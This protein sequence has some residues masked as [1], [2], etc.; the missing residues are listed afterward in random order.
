MRKNISASIAVGTLFAAFLAPDAASEDPQLASLNPAAIFTHLDLDRAD[1]GAVR[2]LVLQGDAPNALR[3]LRDHY[4]A[5]YPLPDGEPKIEQA[6]LETADRTA[7]HIFQWGP[8]EPAEY[9]KDVDWAWDP[10]GD[11]EWVAAM[12]RFYWADALVQAYQATRDERY[13]EAFVEL[14]S[15]WIAKHPLQERDK[16]HPVYTNW[17][18]YPW[19]DIQTGI[20]AT[21]LCRAFPVMVHAE[22]FTPEFLGVFLASLYDHQAKTEFYPM[23]KVHN[24]AIFEQRGFVN[25]AYTFPEFRDS[26]RWLELALGRARESLLDQ[27][28]GD[29]V[30]REWSAGYHQGVLRDAVEMMGRMEERGISV[31]EDYRARV[32][33][34]WE[35][36]F[37]MSTPD[38]GY[39]M[40]GD[41]SRPY[42]SPAQRGKM[43]LYGSMLLAAEVLSDPRFAALALNQTDELPALKSY[44]FPE[45][46]MYFLRDAWGPKQIYFALHCSPPGISGHDQPDNGTFEVCAFGRWLMTDSGYYTYGHDPEARAWHR[47]TRVHNTLTLDG[48]D[49]QV[50]GKHLLWKQADRFDA[51]CVENASYDGLTHRRSVWFVDHAFFVVLDEA[52][53][54]AKGTPSLHFQFAPGAIAVNAGKHK[55]RTGFGDANVL[56]WMAPAAPVV[57][58]EEDGWFAYEYGKREARKAVR[59]AATQEAPFTF[60]TLLIP[61]EGVTAPEAHAAVTV[62]HNAGDGR[63]TIEVRACGNAWRIGRDLETGEAWCEAQ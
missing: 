60:L 8:Y 54:T 38:L 24:K 48:K 55:V 5:K 19:L 44:A 52:I 11:I 23:G 59:V 14:T 13:A 18:G 21:N 46:G 58:E 26:Q 34:M 63:V 51:L 43:T 7:K 12:Y 20:R 41:T 10:R 40:F 56:L 53:G 27:T 62:P 35:Y 25:V 2:E 17:K 29:G 37:A 50:A 1:L 28:T 36:L 3:S 47:Q 45:A 6:T 57:F 42:P 61:Y 16:T 15:D 30:Q 33:A 4:R 22:A 31:P 32:R 39:A 49:T 9:G